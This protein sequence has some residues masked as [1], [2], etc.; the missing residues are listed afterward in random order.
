[1]TAKLVRLALP[2]CASSLLLLLLLLSFVACDSA[3]RQDAASVVSAIRRFRSAD[4]ASTPSAVDA[5]KATPCSSDDACRTKQT[6][7]VSGE[8]TANA[9]RLKSEVEQG[10]VD[11]ER[12]TL[13]KDSPEAK[14][15]PKKLDQAETLL[16]KGLEGLPACDEQVV[17]LRRKHHF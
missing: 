14:E 3:D 8:A 12:G 7:L 16:K 9:L 5:L 1:M 13:A 11:L 2:A 17:A 15:M 4:N 6:C 10:L